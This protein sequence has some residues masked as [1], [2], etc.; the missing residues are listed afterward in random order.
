MGHS[1]AA[2]H[3]RWTE[4][5][6]KHGQH[7]HETFVALIEAMGGGV[8]RILRAAADISK[9]GTIIHEAGTVRMGDD[10]KKR[11]P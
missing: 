9:G 8:V 11:H 1:G 6:I 4:H 5:E 10:P 3:W 7:M 2:I